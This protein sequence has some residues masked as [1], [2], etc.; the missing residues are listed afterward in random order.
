MGWLAKLA[1][2][3]GINE[4]LAIRLKPDLAPLVFAIWCKSALQELASIN[5][6]SGS[7][8]AEHRDGSTISAG[9]KL[10]D[11]APINLCSKSELLLGPALLSSQ[12][13]EIPGNSVPQVAHCAMNA[14]C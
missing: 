9:L 6:K 14:A 2:L 4:S 11:V 5:A 3:T 10:A 13:P 1:I 7:K 12:A 8:F